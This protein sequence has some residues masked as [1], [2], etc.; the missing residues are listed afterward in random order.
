[1]LH[2]PAASQVESARRNC[3][4]EKNVQFRGPV[5]KLPVSWRQRQ[6]LPPALSLLLPTKSKSGWRAGAGGSAR[7]NKSLARRRG[8]ALPSARPSP[9]MS[10]SVCLPRAARWTCTFQRSPSLESMT[11]E[12]CWRKWALQTCS[13]TRQISHASPRTPS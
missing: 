1:M 5:G 7:G 6:I 3:R 8:A 10:N 4:E 12:M 13:P 11:S 9:G 2:G